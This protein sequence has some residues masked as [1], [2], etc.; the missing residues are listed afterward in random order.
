MS[1]GSFLLETQY[2]D[3]RPSSCGMKLRWRSDRHNMD[4]NR[5]QNQ[6]SSGEEQNRNLNMR[7]FLS[8][9]G[10]ALRRHHT[11]QTGHH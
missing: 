5:G 6:N 1:T 8:S 7:G 9:T 3:Q 2:N 10:F 4:L 11:P